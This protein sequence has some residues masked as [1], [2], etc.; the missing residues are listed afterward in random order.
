MKNKKYALSIFALVAGGLFCLPQM[1]LASSSYVATECGIK[2]YQGIYTQKGINDGKPYYQNDKNIFIFFD[3]AAG[4]WV[5]FNSMPATPS[6]DY[7][8]YSTMGIE[9]GDGETPFV[10]TW[11]WHG[12]EYASPSCV[13]SLDGTASA[14]KTVE[15]KTNQLAAGA[16]TSTGTVIGQPIVIGGVALLFILVGAV[17][18]FKKKKETVVKEE[19]STE[20]I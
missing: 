12:R 15:S 16:V 3:K 9:G 11:V 13:I 8:E 5:W 20:V 1:T 18:F 10:G 19:K 14:V 6:V 2:D 4:F 7:T 17:F